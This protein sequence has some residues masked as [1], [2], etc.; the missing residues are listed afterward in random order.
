MLMN[1]IK[2]IKE[3]KHLPQQ[4]SKYNIP[5]DEITININNPEKMQ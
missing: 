4:S 2:M 5:K 3:A 1:N